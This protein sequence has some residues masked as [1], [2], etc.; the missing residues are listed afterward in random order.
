[1]S[2]LL[3]DTNVIDQLLPLV[4]TETDPHV[5]NVLFQVLASHSEPRV[6]DALLARLVKA[7]A[8][9]RR[10]IIFSLR[11]IR[12]QRI[13]TALEPYLQD[14]D[15]GV[16]GETILSLGMSGDSNI[17]DTLVKALRDKALCS[18]AVS[19][20]LNYRDPRLGP[21]LLALLADPDNK[22]SRWEIIHG[23]AVNPA[24]GMVEQ[25]L[26]YKNDA[27]LR[28]IVFLALGRCRDPHAETV[29]YETLLG[30][31]PEARGYAMIAINILSVA[32]LVK[33][34]L[35][36]DAFLR[37]KVGAELGKRWSR[38]AKTHAR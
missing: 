17:V 35:G 15:P 34:F 13:F 37:V 26:K 28:E 1:M 36:N 8:Q 21:P 16:R 3:H 23:L 11:G 20:C 22:I 24:D 27:Q 25:L 12:E 38:L 32:E 14:P 33:L 30:D 7:D 2:T 19:V 31:D 6:I 29:I 5:C 9:I 4:Q 18:S 10:G